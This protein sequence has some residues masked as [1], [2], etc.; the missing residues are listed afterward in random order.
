MGALFAG[1]I[2]APLTSV[3]MIFELTQDYQ[4]FL[5]LMI[6]NMLSFV[7]ARHYQSKPLYRALLEQDNVHLPDMRARSTFPSWRAHEI[8]TREF[9]MVPSGAT[10]ATVANSFVED[11]LKC[12]PVGD[13]DS[14]I[15][16]VTW[17]QVQKAMTTGLGRQTDIIDRDEK[18][19]PRTL[20]PS[21]RGG[22]GTIG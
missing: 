8:M 3:F 6:A 12:L 15:G 2:R 9:T 7:I 1:I 17:E 10:V 4:I 16:L 11:G 22:A 13:N 18:L 19:S 20:R 14:L 5:P 21:D